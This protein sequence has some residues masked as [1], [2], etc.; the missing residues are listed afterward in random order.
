MGL[1]LSEV[2]TI[3]Y[4]FYKFQ[5]LHPRSRRN[6]F[7]NKSSD[8]ADRPSGRKLRLQLGPW[9]HGRRRE[10]D[11]SKAKAWLGRERAGE[12]CRLT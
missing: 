10:L 4:E 12:W 7:T 5:H 8:F 6:G 1:H 2:S 9:P 3:F 11:S